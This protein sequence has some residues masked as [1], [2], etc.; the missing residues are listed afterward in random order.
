[1]AKSK[2]TSQA[3]AEQINASHNKLTQ[4]LRDSITSF[5]RHSSRGTFLFTEQSARTSDQD[6]EN[7]YLKGIEV[8]S[9]N[10]PNPRLSIIISDGEDIETP[11]EEWHSFDDLI[12]MLGELEAKRYS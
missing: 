2:R 8:H 7:H 12:W 9:Q 11:I 5:F 4:K 10:E 6:W 3:T 1:M